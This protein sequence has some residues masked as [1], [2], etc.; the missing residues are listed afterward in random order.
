MSFTYLLMF[1]LAGASVSMAQSSNN[2]FNY[3]GVARDADGEVLSNI[4]LLLE[5]SLYS[6]ADQ[7]DF[8]LERRS[9][10]TTNEFGVFATVI[11]QV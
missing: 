2:G 10:I 9:Y 11:G 5:V 1:L 3:Q 8:T 6:D 7:T 4:N